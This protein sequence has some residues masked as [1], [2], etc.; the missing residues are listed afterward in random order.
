MLARFSS[1]QS[2]V[3]RRIENSP[4]ADGHRC[5]TGL[6]AG[7]KPIVEVFC[8]QWCTLITPLGRYA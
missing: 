7:G 5:G 2:W 3:S 1:P 6:P 8:D 4:C